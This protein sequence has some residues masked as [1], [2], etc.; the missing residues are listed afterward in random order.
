MQQSSDIRTT[1]AMP[2]DSVLV[3]DWPFMANTGKAYE[4]LTQAVFSQIVNQKAVDTIAVEHDVVLQGRTTKHQ[5][6]VYWEFEVGGVRY[7]TVVQCKD[8]TSPVDQGELLKLKAVLD[9]LPEQ[10]RGIFVTRTG[11]QSGAKD[12]ADAHGIVLYELREPLPG[13]IDPSSP[14]PYAGEGHLGRSAWGYKW[15]RHGCRLNAQDLASP[16]DRERFRSA[17]RSS[18]TSSA[19]RG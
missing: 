1:E 14:A 19:N 12:F 10:P 13:G 16:L 18:K 7:R 8:W 15:T 6:D 4:K 17:C 5:I 3:Y 9:D 11:Y 2:G